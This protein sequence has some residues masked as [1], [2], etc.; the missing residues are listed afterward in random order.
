MASVQTE[1]DASDRSSLA[2]IVGAVLA[3]YLIPIEWNFP[4]IPPGLDVVRL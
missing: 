2:S 3:W 1:I 4:I